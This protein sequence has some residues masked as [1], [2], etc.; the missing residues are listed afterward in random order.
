MAVRSWIGLGS[1]LDNPQV[2]LRRA[3]AAL[4]DLP[5]STLD[6]ISPLY[7]S[8]PLGPQDQPWFLNA[9]AR[10]A[11]T[12]PPLE[13]LDALQAIEAAHDRKRERRWG[14]R[15]LDLDILI[16]GERVENVERLSLPH[17]GVGQRAFVLYPLNDID[18]QL[19]VPGLGTVSELA[20]AVSGDGL[21]KL[22]PDDGWAR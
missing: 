16:Y 14:P 4:A 9:V 10:L 17:P 12:L 3:V 15:T 11:T 20:A 6:A 1:N 5:G 22:E 8:P 7:R 19:D 21:E 2:Q 13:L 18:P